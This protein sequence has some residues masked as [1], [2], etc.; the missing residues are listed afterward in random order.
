MFTKETLKQILSAELDERARQGY[1]V[2][3][4]QSQLESAAKSYDSLFS[5]AQEIRKAPIRKDWPYREPDGLNEI[6]A[7]CDPRRVR[8]VIRTLV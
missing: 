3:N 2:K 8:G 4:L 1:E 5:I 6:L 7:E